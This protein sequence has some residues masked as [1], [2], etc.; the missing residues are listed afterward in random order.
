MLIFTIFCYRHSW[1]DKVIGRV[2][3]L[4]C[5]FKKIAKLSKLK[6]Q[7]PKNHHFSFSALRE[8]ALSKPVLQIFLSLLSYECCYQNLFCRLFFRHFTTN[9]IIKTCS[10]DFSFSSLL[11]WWYQNLFYKLFFLCF[12]MNGAI[13]TCSADFSYSALLWIVLSKPA[14]QLLLCRLCYEWRSLFRGQTLFQL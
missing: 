2:D 6:S 1:K 4:L 7:Y 5:I 9:G 11:K 8:M 12:T 14:L 3:I 10:A 13:K